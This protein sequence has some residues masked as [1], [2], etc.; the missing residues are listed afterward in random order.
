MIL[1]IDLASKKTGYAFFNNDNENINLVKSGI[2]ETPH[3]DALYRQGKMNM[4][5]IKNFK[6][7]FDIFWMNNVNFFNKTHHVVIE[8][9]IYNKNP[10]VTIT[11]SFCHGVF[12]SFLSNFDIEVHYIDNKKW[13]NIYYGNSNA[14]KEDIIEYVE[15]QYNIKVISNDESDAIGIGNAFLLQK[16]EE[17]VLL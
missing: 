4:I 10:K 2:I 16:K 6:E 13:K 12:L 11:L 3:N 1:A 17:E 7:A 15:S 8:S 9:P 14:S 5:L